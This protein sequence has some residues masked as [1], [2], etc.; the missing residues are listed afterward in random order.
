MNNF[1]WN[2][3]EQFFNT[4]RGSELECVVFNGK[5]LQFDNLDFI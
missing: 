5:G 4:L 1:V 2:A 3:N